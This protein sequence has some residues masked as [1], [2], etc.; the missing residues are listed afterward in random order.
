MDKWKKRSAA[1]FVAVF[2]LL[3]PALGAVSAYRLGD[4]YLNDVID[5]NEWTPELG[6]RFET[7]IASTF[8]GKF[9]F[10][11]FNG[12][13]RRLLGQ[14]QMNNITKLNNGYLTLT[15]EAFD[16]DILRANAE[17]IIQLDRYLAQNGTPLLFVITPHSVSPYDPQLPDGVQ[18]VS[19]AALDELAGL[20][21]QAGVQT[22]DIRTALHEDGID[23]YQM[24]FR[25]DHHWTMEGGFYAF[26]K[27]CEW[28]RGATGAEVDPKVLDPEQYTVEVYP[29]WHLGSYGQRVGPLYAGVD[30]FSLWIPKFSTDLSRNGINGTYESL[31]IDRRALTEKD[32]TSR[33]TYDDVLTPANTGN[34]GTSQAKN[35]KKLLLLSDS[36]GRAVAPFLSLAYAEVHNGETLFSAEDLQAYGPDAVIL[37]FHAN[38]LLAENC[39]RFVDPDTPAGGQTA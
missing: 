33:S 4:Y 3:V 28:M 22:L 39:I 2:C 36:F 35:D 13:V 25:T 30:D 16:D 19:N 17:T 10:V 15:R 14:R 1:L 8:F 20:L 27:I 9:A 37:V 26:G 18:D 6:T 21:Q 23:Q 34:F 32:L 12:G 31:S 5:Y 24:M 7:N 11:S 38:S 29:E